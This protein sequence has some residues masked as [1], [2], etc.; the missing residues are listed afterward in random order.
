MGTANS[1]DQI[2]DWEERSRRL[3]ALIQAPALPLTDVGLFLDVPLSTLDMLRA[4]GQGPRTFKI[5][6]RLYV[7]QLDL[8]NWLDKL[9]E[10]A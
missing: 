2:P 1:R 4:K 5:G 9:A 10:A 3:L 6:R 8:R 7:R